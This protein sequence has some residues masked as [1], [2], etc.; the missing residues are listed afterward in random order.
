VVEASDIPEDVWIELAAGGKVTAKHPLSTRETTFAGP[1]RVRPCV[2]HREEAW[3]ARGSF[4]SVVSSGERP[5]GGEWIVTPLGVIRYGA[6][7]IDLA[8]GPA[9]GAVTKAELK[10]SSGTAYVWTGDQASP[11]KPPAPAPALVAAPPSDDGWTKVEGTRT[12]TISVAKGGKPEELAQVAVDRC[13][14]FAAAAKDVSLA[15]SAPDAGL[16]HLAP[17]QVIA[18]QLARAACGVASVRVA[19]LDASPAQEGFRTTLKE[20]EAEWKRASRGGHE[21]GRPH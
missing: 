16:R 6:A 19:A 9:T 1:G 10:V 21:R 15:I 11:L 12:M 4:E 8:I 3:L 14:S 18:R 5:S 2:G 13:K 17:K 7:K 20:A